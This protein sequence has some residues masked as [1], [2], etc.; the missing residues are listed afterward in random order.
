MDSDITAIVNVF[1][2]EHLLDIQIQAI[3][4]QTVKPKNIIIFNN[5]NKK[6]DLTKYK[7]DPFYLVMDCNTNTG[8]WMRFIISSMAKTKYVCIFDDDTI[9]EINWLKNC[10]DSMNKKEALYGT[11][12]VIFSN[13]NGY[14][15]LR[16]YGWDSINNGNNNVAKP[17]D[18]V[19]HSWFFKKEWMKY[20]NAEAPPVNEHFSVGEDIHFSRMLQKYG[21]IPT[22]VPPHPRNDLSMFGSNPVSAYKFGCDGNS[23]SNLIGSN[24]NNAYCEAI[25]KDFKILIHRQTATSVSDFD[26]FTKKI[27]DNECFA[28]IR[29]ADGEYHVLQNTTLTNIDNWT[30]VTNGKLCVDLKNAINIASNKNCYVGIPCGTCNLSM[31]RWYV[32]EF[33]LN[34]MYTTFS[35][36]FVNNNWKNW[37]NFLF[38]NKISFIFIGPNNL[39]PNFNV[40]QYISIPLYLVNEWDTKGQEYLSFVLTE[41]KK[42]K[43][44]LFL[45]SAGPIAK[46][47]IA[48]AWNEHPHNIYL[49]IGSSLYLFAKGQTNRYYINDSELSKLICKFDSSVINI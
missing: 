21:N 46:I 45:F 7:N 27:K 13:D 49:D 39:P 48:N 31:A 3:L 41:I 12:G 28:L 34:P 44:K 17:V 22:Y 35:N 36:I 40:N 4:N 6:V 29:P 25:S 37:I 47:I 16:R 8:V 38:V 42:H 23:G 1:K 20:F 33:N 19:G 15:V 10:L 11:I 14:N 18:I 5:G 9:P 30:F 43:N 2:R 26:M 24:F 32:S